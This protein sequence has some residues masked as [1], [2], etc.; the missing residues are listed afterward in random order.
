[1]R[2]LIWDNLLSLF[3]SRIA[4]KKSHASGDYPIFKLAMLARISLDTTHETKLDGPLV[5]MGAVVVAG[6]PNN[7]AITGIENGEAIC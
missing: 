6:A 5:P 2:N 3:A 1:M 7:V 4:A